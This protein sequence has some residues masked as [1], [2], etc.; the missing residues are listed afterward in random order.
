ME[1]EKKFFLR[2]HFFCIKCI[3]QPLKKKC[4]A[5]LLLSKP[6]FTKKRYFLVKDSM[7]S[8]KILF[9]RMCMSH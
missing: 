1:S 7:R 4:F 5:F 2:V 3:S 9:F 6:F 8:E